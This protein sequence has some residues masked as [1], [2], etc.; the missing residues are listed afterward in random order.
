MHS[1]SRSHLLQSHL[2]WEQASPLD[3]FCLHLLQGGDAL[4]LGGD[5][6]R[7]TSA[8]S[9]TDQLA[10]LAIAS[11]MSTGQMLQ[12]DLSQV[13]WWLCAPGLLVFWQ[14]CNLYDPEVASRLRTHGNFRNKFGR[15]AMS[16]V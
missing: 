10:T 15:A 12:A 1:W 16:E 14:L 9:L 6:A 4:R 8:I 5:G 13:L 3:G 11:Q 2:A 7:L